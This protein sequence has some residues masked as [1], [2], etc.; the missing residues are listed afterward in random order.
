MRIALVGDRSE[1]VVAHRAIP[2]ALEL[3]AKALG[4]D[5]TPVWV[6][7]AHT[8]ASLASFAGVWCTPGSPYAS[9]DGA[10]SMIRLARQQSVPFLG[11]CGGFQHALIEFAR[12]VLGV[13][14]EHAESAPGSPN[15][16][17][18]L[19]ACALVNESAK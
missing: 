6:Q 14:A 7:T 15:A 10:L 4:C 1:A 19:L 3:T 17:I 12:D 16:I 8:P 11:T 2:L 18:T 13:P 5:V 9:M